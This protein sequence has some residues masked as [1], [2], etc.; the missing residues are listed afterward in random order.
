MA[1]NSTSVEY[2]LDENS[3]SKG[4][5][6]EDIGDTESIVPDSDPDFLDIEISTVGSSE[7]SSDHTDFWDEWDDNGHNA[8]NDATVIASAN[9]PNWTTNLTDIT[10]E[11][12]FSG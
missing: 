6:N 12:F 5:K 8:V 9:I 2:N 11:P 4:Y 1:E 7:I 3:D 10:I